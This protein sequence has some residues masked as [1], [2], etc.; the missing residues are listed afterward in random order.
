MSTGTDQEVRAGPRGQNGLLAIHAARIGGRTRLLSLRCHPPLQVLR[1]AYTEPELP[2]LAAVT[3]CSPAG[4][5]LQGDRLSIDVVVDAGAQLRLETQSATRLYAMPE[6]SASGLV[7]LKA[8][9]DAYL[10]YVADPLIPF[11]NACYRQE[12]QW[13]VHES[14]TLIVGEVI[15][16]GREARGEKARYRRV[17]SHI[18]VTRP[19]G[20]T[21][22]TDTCVLAPNGAQ[23]LGFLGDY[24]AVGSL[25]VVSTMFKAASFVSLAEHPAVVHSH[26]GWSDL[27][28]HAGAWFKVLA[29]DSAT[30]TAAVRVAWECAR[31]ALLGLGLPPAR[32]F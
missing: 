20:Q 25:F 30:A 18:D 3:I 31:R 17:E 5:V 4:G 14:A 28:N 9:P 21:L 13:E 10:E 1:A 27:P 32:R 11:A 19:G 2:S 22:F 15:T 29:D 16:A 26:A 6:A 12:S 24:S 8:G 23:Q 7:S